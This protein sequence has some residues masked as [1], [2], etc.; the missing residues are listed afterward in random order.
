MSTPT[1][2]TPKIS[3]KLLIRTVILLFAL[4]VLFGGYRYFESQKSDFNRGSSSAAGLIS[5]TKRTD[6]GAEVVLIKPDGS[7]KETT[8]Y[9]PG[10][11]DREPIWRPDGRFLFFTSDRTQ[12]TYHVYRW[13]PDEADAEPRTIG[14]RARTSPS[15]PAEDVPDAN[16]DML[17]ISGGTVQSFDPKTKKTPQVLPPNTA[18]ITSNTDEQGG[19]EALFESTYGSLG[20]S[21][22]YARWCKGNQYIAAIMKRDSGEV[23]VLQDMTPISDANSP[24]VGKLP[25]IIPVV[26]G[27]HVTF[28]VSPK[29]GTILFSVQ[30]FEWPDPNAIPDQFKKGNH[31]TT[32]FRHMLGFIVPG[33]QTGP[34]AIIASPDDSHSFG[35]PAV[36][37]DGSKVL[38][39]VGKYDPSSQSVHPSGLFSFPVQHLA[40]QAGTRLLDG[41]VYEPTWSHDGKLIAFALRANGKRDIYT[42]HDDGSA[43]TNITNGKGDFGNPKFNPQEAAGAAK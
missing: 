33:E 1:S 4:A 30:G 14:T 13:N 9:K 7:I 22:S 40:A 27:D 20:T 26:A 3:Q 12:N 16:D 21:F 37:P 25:K 2:F 6:D 29:D 19:S 5:A 41:E 31:I 28:D 36:A 43:Q 17:I 18:T 39:T 32:P 24:N 38:V 34:Q 11:T 10:V 42:M 8:S 23:L 35:T 15:F